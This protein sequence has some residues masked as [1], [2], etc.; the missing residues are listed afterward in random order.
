M[1]TSVENSDA[2]AWIAAVSFA[3]AQHLT[4]PPAWLMAG[5]RRNDL[6][7]TLDVRYYFD[8]ALAGMPARTDG[9]GGDWSRARIYG[10]TSASSAGRAVSG[11]AEHAMFWRAPPGQEPVA[12]P[13]MQPLADIVNDLRAWHT[14][15]RY[16]VELGFEN[17]AA[18]ISDVPMPWIPADQMFHPELAL[19]LTA[20]GQLAAAEVLPP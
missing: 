4:M 7:D 18:A 19:R 16:A 10:A 17:R 1:S 11:L 5:F 13:A 14:H 3:A 12:S 9:F 2:A 6:S 8:P 20:L 15:M